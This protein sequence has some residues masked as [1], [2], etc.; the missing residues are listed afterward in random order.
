[1]IL[2]FRPRCEY[3]DAMSR[4]TVFAQLMDGKVRCSV[5]TRSGKELVL[6]G[7]P[8][9]LNPSLTGDS[10]LSRNQSLISNAWAYAVN[11]CNRVMLPNAEEQ[12]SATR[13]ANGH[14]ATA[15]W[16]AD[17]I[18]E[19]T[20]EQRS[21]WCSSCISYSTHRIVKRMKGFIPLSLCE[22]CGSPTVACVVPKCP[23]MAV[24]NFKSIQ[25]RKYCAEHVHAVPSFERASM[26]IDSLTDY[27]EFL[28]YEKHNFARL[29]KQVAFS[30]IGAVAVWPLALVAAPAVGGAVGALVG[31]YSGAAATSFGLA[32]I[33]GGSIAA[34]G[35]GMAGGTA[36]VTAVGTALGGGLSASI[37]N[38]YVEEDKSFHIEM[39]KGGSGVPVVVCNGFLSEEGK[40]W[41][42][43]K[44]IVSERY[45]DS[46]VYRVHWG[47]KELKDLGFVTRDGL[48]KGGL[49]KFLA[50][51]SKQA[52]KQSA[53][54]IGP[55]AAL[56]SASDML[57]SPWYLAR[58]R[59]EKTGVV[60]ADILARTVESP[61]VLI[62]HSL[63]ARVMTVAAQTLGT[64]SGEARLDD[65]HL[66][67]NAVGAKADWATLVA[68]VNGKVFN[69]HSS[70][71]A[72]LKLIYKIAQGGQNAAGFSGFVLSERQKQ[73]IQNIDVSIQVDGHSEYFQ[74]VQLK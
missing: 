54:K 51:I 64:K 22:A 65:V 34:G 35:L 33:G 60:L 57:K 58:S 61:F 10:E 41:A 3:D 31:G 49:G 66:L 46:P 6:T 1:M 62:G 44:Q 36:I 55:L 72:V 48:V 19:L 8:E 39:L 42:E 5:K 7:T 26:K 47:A 32:M 59:A 13:L 38:A 20:T 53:H 25:E 74:N 21:G 69:Y 43:W 9:T 45:P 23:N 29:S 17:Y 12:K 14:Q 28:T 11:T 73:K 70:N 15:A 16:I 2:C 63:G 4:S 52:M 40:G 67:G 71:D 24:K 68:S 37:T 30:A 56:F 27:K 18:D 50:Q